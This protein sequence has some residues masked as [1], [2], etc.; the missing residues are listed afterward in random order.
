[1]NR[2]TATVNRTSREPPHTPSKDATTVREEHWN[3]EHTINA[4]IWTASR[5]K[6]RWIRTIQN[7]TKKIITVSKHTLL[8]MGIG[9]EMRKAIIN[10]SIPTRIPRV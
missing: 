2:T 8:H 3:E 5:E 4:N 9:G 10:R 7:S 1:M 6:D